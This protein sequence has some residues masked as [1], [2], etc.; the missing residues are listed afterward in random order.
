MDY[1]REPQPSEF[2]VNY[3]LEFEPA[4]GILGVPGSSGI[5]ARFMYFG[6]PEFTVHQQT[7][8][9]VPASVV[10]AEGALTCVSRTSHPDLLLSPETYFAK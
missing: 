4:T 8:E 5:S 10:C 6:G 1:F 9:Y 3:Y 7:P 2:P